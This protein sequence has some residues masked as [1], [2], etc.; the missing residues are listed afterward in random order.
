M[1]QAETEARRK[2]EQAD[3]EARAGKAAAI[4]EVADAAGQRNDVDSEAPARLFYERSPGTLDLA[5][6]TALAPRRRAARRGVDRAQ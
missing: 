6:G 1:A 4:A 3:V 2:A 5:V